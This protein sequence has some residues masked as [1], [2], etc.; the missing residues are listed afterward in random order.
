[1]NIILCPVKRSVLLFFGVFLGLLGCLSA[2]STGSHA[3]NIYTL[4]TLTEQEWLSLSTD[5]RLTALNTSN[6]HARNQTFLGRFGRNED[7]YPRWGYDYYEMSDKYENFS[8]RN[9]EKYRVIEDRRE[10]WYYNQFGDRITKMTKNASIWYEQINDD[11]TSERYNPG[12]YVNSQLGGRGTTTNIDGIWLARESTD[13]WAISAIGA[14][15]L[16]TKLTP[17]TMSIPNVNGMKVDFQSANYTA[18]MVNSNMTEYIGRFIVSNDV[19]LRG[20]QL[21]RKFGALTLGATYA[22]MYAVQTNRDGGTDLRGT[23][24]DFTPVPMMYAVRVLDDSP[25][26]GGGPIIHDVKIKING[27]YRPDIL[28]QVIL[29]DI[30][31]DLVTAVVSKS[32]QDYL[33]PPHSSEYTIRYDQLSEE[34]MPKYLDY[35]YLNDYNRGWNS[36]I[37]TENFDS[38]KARQ[39]YRTIDPG[40]RPLQVNNTEYALYL[41]DIATITENVRRVEVEITIANDYRIQTSQIFTK[42]SQGGHDASGDNY[43]HYNAQYWTTMAQ[44]EGNIKDSSN[45]RTVSIDFGYEVANTIYGFDCHFNYRGFKVNGEYVTNNHRYMYADGIPGSGLLAMLLRDITPR[46]GHRSSQTDHAYYLIVEKDWDHIGFAGEY[47]KMGKFY[48]PNFNYFVAG[49][50]GGTFVNQC[51]NTVR[52]SMIEDNDDDDQYPDTMYNSRIMAL[53][54]QSLIDPD[55]VFPGNDDD[56]DSY[57]DNEKNFNGLPDYDEPFLM[58]DVD[59]DEFVFGDDFNNNTIPDFREDD[60]KYDTPYE[61]DRQG[62]H[63]YLRFTPQK[64]INALLG[65]M[66]TGGVGLDTRTYDDYLKINIKYDIFTVGRIFAEYRNERIQDNIQDKFVVVPPIYKFSEGISSRRAF[67]QRNLYF[68]EVEYRN[69]KVNKFFLDSKIRV[70]PAITLENHIRYERNN[71]LEGTMYD[72][73]FQPH[74]VVSTLAI[75]N[76]IACT[77]QYGKWIVSPGIKFRLYKKDRSQ[78]LH[79]LDHWLMRIPLVTL[80]YVLS[81]ATNITFGM[82]GC[83]GLELMYKDYIQDHNDFRKTNYVV[84]LENKSQYF[85]FEVWG[86]VGF[87][88]ERVTYDKSY[89]KFEEYRSSTFFVQLLLGY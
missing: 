73:T 72:N 25:Q 13:D 5:E 17:L 63:F 71:Q 86:G 28:P 70:I 34:V 1:M 9:F 29:D 46:S 69:S 55:G 74:D 62:R 12:G 32:Q 47:F 60:M 37:M 59:P 77:K 11:G 2:F 41:F 49:E 16:R 52:F 14:G 33:Q 65:S 6:N 3:Q 66:R 39:H 81:P 53:R 19:M 23:V 15:A 31:Y 76:K 78:S 26:D 88:A 83:P 57:P 54:I 56:H 35:L 40:N 24:D 27:R 38:T 61:L 87:K 4:R 45:L 21:R 51:N 75:V 22:N 85:G 68:D 67:Y 64:N 30:R 89:R 48:R 8:F 10:K 20:L 44:A 84:Q 36:N 42:K 79:P 7:L 50:K 58:F 18:S 80:K 43:L 82:Q